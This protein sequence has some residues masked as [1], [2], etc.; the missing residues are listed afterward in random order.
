MRKGKKCFKIPRNLINKLNYPKNGDNI[1][2]REVVVLLKREKNM[3]E[4]HGLLG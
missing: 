3:D 4:I 1:G 2:V